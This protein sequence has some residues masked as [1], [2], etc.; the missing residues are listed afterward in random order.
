MADSVR[1]SSPP[2]RPGRFGEPERSKERV[3]PHEDC[4]VF[5]IGDLRDDAIVKGV[6]VKKGLRPGEH[7]N[8]YPHRE[9]EA[10]KD[11]KGIEDIVVFPHVYP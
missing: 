11:G 5:L 3:G 7:G 6:D 2:Q 9:T 4:A 1:T 10:V 8:D